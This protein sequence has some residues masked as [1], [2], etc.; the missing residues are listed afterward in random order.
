VYSEAIELDKRM[1]SGKASVRSRPVFIMQCLLG[2]D[3]T[4]RGDLVSEALN[5]TLLEEEITGQ[6]DHQPALQFGTN[7]GGN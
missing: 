1:R 6:G 7:V 4:P 2:G 3:L 5:E